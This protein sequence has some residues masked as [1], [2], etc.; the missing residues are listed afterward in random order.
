MG[1]KTHKDL[2]VYKDAMDFV[3]S[4]YQVT[5]SFPDNERYG[6]TSQMRRAAVSIPSNIAEGAA[7]K[8]TKEFIQFLHHSLGSAS[9]I[10]TQLELAKRLSFIEEVNTLE[11]NVHSI[12]NRLTAL[13]KSLQKNLK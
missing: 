7:R 10:E 11:E 9:E 6:L 8:N 4:I 1:I 13:I 3:V 2:D 12:I 5:N